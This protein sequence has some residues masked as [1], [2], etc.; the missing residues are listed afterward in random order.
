MTTP[1]YET[2]VLAWSNEEAR[3]LRAGQF[4]LLD[5]EPSAE[6]LPWPSPRPGWVRPHPGQ[7]TGPGHGLTGV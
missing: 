5:L 7:E 1:C 4:G 6:E 2:D 3:L